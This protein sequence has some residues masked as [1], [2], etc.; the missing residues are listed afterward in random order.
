MWPSRVVCCFN[1]HSVTLEIDV[2]VLQVAAGHRR[3]CSWV[4][5]VPRLPVYQRFSVQHTVCLGR[6]KKY[7][8]YTETQHTQ[9]SN[10]L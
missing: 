2:V 9:V 3:L 8:V 1:A 5:T 6:D 10:R 4:Q 7:R